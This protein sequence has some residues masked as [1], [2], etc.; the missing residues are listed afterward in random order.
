MRRGFLRDRAGNVAVFT[1]LF[2]IPLLA[3]AGIAIDY[4][5]ASM[6]RNFLQAEADAAALAAAKG[7]ASS[8]DQTW[9]NNLRSNVQQRFEDERLVSSL[10]AS[11]SW[12]MPTD[13]SVTA[14]ATV[15]VTILGVIPGLSKQMDVSVQAVARFSQ[16]VLTYN[17][18]VVSQ[19]DPDA[20]DYNRIYV[21]CYNAKNKNKAD[22]GRTKMT[23][24]ADNA[25]TT[26]NYTMPTCAAGE[27]MSYRLR[28]VRNARTQK[29]K[30]D[31]SRA[32]FYEYYTDTVLNGGVESYNLS[33]SLIETV[34]C[35]NR[36][37]CKPERQGGVIPEGANRT[38]RRATEACAP[39]KFMYYGWEDRPP[40]G[41]GSDRDYNDIRIII[42]CPTVATTGAE[43][44]WL[45][46]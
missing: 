26:Y 21:Y 25:G 44:V 13:F 42:E 30:W 8:N 6:V 15:P 35:S 14:S 32:E 39:G 9:V 46:K 38:P 41:G 24:I 11:G 27:T 4:A 5:R 45:I 33:V 31:S 10:N 23:A 7:G 43:N 34:L 40:E 18:P 36:T 29:S 2:A 12:V 16:P 20:A 19:L 22:K 17:P 37:I 3:A 28:N 1:A